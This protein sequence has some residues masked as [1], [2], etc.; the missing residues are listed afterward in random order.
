MTGPNLQPHQPT[1]GGPSRSG[2]R[3]FRVLAGAVGLALLLAAVGC[4]SKDGGSASTTKNHDPLVMGPG[5]IPKQN[6]P[7]PDRGTAG[8]DKPD[9]LL[10][11]PT[12]RDGKTGS[13][14]NSGAERWKN[15][16]FIPG[17]DTTPAALAGR[18]RDDD[19]GLR[20]ETPGAGVRPAGGTVSPDTDGLLTELQKYGV[21]R[22]DYGFDREGGTALFRARVPIGN[23]RVRQYTGQGATPAEAVRQVLEQV[24]SDRN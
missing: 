13:S 11:S 21:K 20:I 1:P 14:Y 15:G 22:G 19:E 10:G 16:P 12:G 3:R 23:D 6:I 18:G 4:K 9:P 8:K 2:S 5:R 7:I 24:K 17:T